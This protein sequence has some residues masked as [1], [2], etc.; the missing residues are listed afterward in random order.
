MPSNSALAGSAGVIGLPSI[1]MLG[2]R[3]LFSSYSTL[4][5]ARLFCA[6]RICLVSGTFAGPRARC[7]PSGGGLARRGGSRRRAR[8]SEFKTSGDGRI[9][10]NGDTK[11]LKISYLFTKDEYGDVGIELEFMVPKGS[12]SGVHV[13][14]RYEVEI[15]DSFG[16]PRGSVNLCL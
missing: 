15:L 10:V 2:I 14:G 7:I 12:N 1:R 3:S 6:L 13:M 9:V 5:H 11:D 16:R 4:Y 8:K